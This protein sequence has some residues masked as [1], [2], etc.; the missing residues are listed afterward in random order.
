MMKILN[1]LIL[2]ITINAFL[3][4]AVVYFETSRPKDAEIFYYCNWILVLYIH[5]LLSPQLE[6]F[7]VLMREEELIVTDCGLI[8]FNKIV[9]VKVKQ[10]W[11][12]MFYSFNYEIIMCTV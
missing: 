1:V 11:K 8:L 2:F 10:V 6:K 4:T 7:K 3:I 9:F 5:I 12:H